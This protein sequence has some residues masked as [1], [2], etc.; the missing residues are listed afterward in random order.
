MPAHFR[1]KYTGVISLFDFV[2]KDTPTIYHPAV[3]ALTSAAVGRYYCPAIHLSAV[4]VFFMDICTR[5]ISSHVRF[6]FGQLDVK[7]LAERLRYFP[8]LFFHRLSP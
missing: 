3:A 7:T 6:Y 2:S 5:I 8:G 4:P 1:I